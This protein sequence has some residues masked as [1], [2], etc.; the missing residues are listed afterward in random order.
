MDLN[1][2]GFSDILSGSYSR[3]GGKFMAGL[4]QVLWGTKD[5]KFSKAEPLKGSDGKPLVI[6]GEDN[7]S[8]TTR[9]C[10]RPFAIDWDG[11]GDLDIVSGNFEGTFFVF[12][13]EGEGRFIPMGELITE[14]D[15]KSPLKVSGAHSDP[16]V[17]DFDGD[18]DLDIVSGSGQGG[19][20]LAR[21]EADKGQAP[22]F[23]GFEEIV[24]AGGRS[25]D[26]LFKPG[27]LPGSPGRSTRVWVHD[28]NEDGKLDLLLGDSVRLQYPAE[29]LS[30]KEF[31]E[32]KEA[33]DKRMAEL[34]KQLQA[35]AEKDEGRPSDELMKRYQ[36][37]WSKRSE[38][39][40][41]DSTG[42]VWACLGK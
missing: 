13:G 10:T 11:D 30:E 21:N 23:K 5:G 35:G 28:L 36:E 18:G 4:F 12:E 22:A 38:F 37:H 16:F 33:W 3:T 40:K 7:D 24:K 20:Q 1:Q 15:G 42:F 39:V 2:D 8:A 34:N 9:I 26:E 19:V 6:P 27:E 25:G 32:K 29:G 14:A 31:A 41:E 17:V